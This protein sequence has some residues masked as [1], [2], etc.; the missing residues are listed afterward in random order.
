MPDL[1]YEA[2]LK[3]SFVSTITN[4]AAPTVSQLTAG[5]PLEQDL[6]PDGLNT[7]SDTASVDNS[8]M[9]ST[10]TTM[11]VGRRSFTGITVKYIRG[12]STTQTAVASALIYGANGFLVV[13]RDKVSTAAWASGDKVE[14]YPVQ[15]GELNPDSPA[16]NTLQAVEVPMMVTSEPR[17][18]SNPA[19]VAT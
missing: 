9:N 1:T 19:T 12:T 17:S 15:I 8:R 10:F 16:P 6:L 5:I 14:V 13:R 7:P 2:M 3:I 18:L 11:T 4:I